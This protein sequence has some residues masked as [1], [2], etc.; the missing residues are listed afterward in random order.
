M[1]PYKTTFPAVLIGEYW[2]G[3]QD[4]L[5]SQYGVART[6]AKRHTTQFRRKVTEYGDTIYN[7]E[8]RHVAEAL[9]RQLA[10][11]ANGATRNVAAGRMQ[12]AKKVS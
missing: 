5:V 9:A 3:V 10:A 1:K 2:Q 8:P 11:A 7:D 4:L 12:S 6:T